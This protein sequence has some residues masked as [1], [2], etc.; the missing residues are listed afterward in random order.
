MTRN[1]T[2]CM[3][4]VLL[5]SLALSCG[6]K[7][8]EVQDQTSSDVKN[9]VVQDHSKV[10]SFTHDGIQLTATNNKDH[11]YEG[12]MIFWNENGDKNKIA[13]VMALSKISKDEKNAY[14]KEHQPVPGL[15]RK[16]KFKEDRLQQL[17][18][19]EQAKKASYYKDQSAAL[20][21]DSEIWVRSQLALGKQDAFDLYCD[22]ALLKFAVSDFLQQN[23]FT[24]RPQP[25]A[26]CSNYYD[27]KGLF[28]SESCKSVKDEAG[29][30]FNCIWEGGI[31]E[32]FALFLKDGKTRASAAQ[33]A[34]FLAIE[35]EK[36][37]AWLKKTDLEISVFRYSKVGDRFK[38]VLEKYNPTAKKIEPLL[39]EVADLFADPAKASLFM[40]PLT[41]ERTTAENKVYTFNDRLHNFHIIKGDAPVLGSEQNELVKLQTDIAQV[42]GQQPHA[43]GIEEERLAV[44]K[45]LRD[46]N[47]SLDQA[48]KNADPHQNNY[49][50]KCDIPSADIIKQFNLA[51]MLLSQLELS[52]AP[53][54]DLISVQLHI[55]SG[56]VLVGC[57]EWSSGVRKDC[58]N[59]NSKDTMTTSF[60]K[61]SGLLTIDLVMNDP[62][63]VGLQE[64][65][66]K[67]GIANFQTIPNDQLKDHI[68]HFEVYPAKYAEYLDI[69]TG[70]V[71]V[72]DGNSILHQG[73]LNFTTRLKE[74]TS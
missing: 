40:D 62:V 18:I 50:N 37:P 33:K 71:Q 38:L 2:T 32:T 24:S 74:K 46:L 53:V 14:L 23:T 60:N 73:S 5:V 65:R 31:L 72:K 4:S 20:A 67:D 28:K 51:S 12:T 45:D 59:P 3:G 66:K 25:L 15:E 1:I 6:V 34:D 7:N 36:L 47:K 41:V 22:A 70:T 55:N 44:I 48:K 8:P 26:I 58:G 63:K 13:E 43:S 52:L 19:E 17:R 21:H 27:K 64:Q 10:F 42:F 57:F 69:L 49:A 68:L 9:P 54:G 30:Y 16:I 35:L 61:D 56:D 39:L 29:N 11:Q